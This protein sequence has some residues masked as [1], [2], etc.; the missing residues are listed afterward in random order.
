MN[1]KISIV[2]AFYNRQALLDK[3]LESIHKSSVQN[4]E[5][6]IV[7]DA[8]AE[9]LVCDEAKIIR[10]DKKDK[11]YTCSAVA[12]NRGFREATGDIVIIQNPECYHVGDILKYVRDNIKNNQYYSFACYAINKDETS[13]FQDGIMP[14]IQNKRFEDGN[15]WYN[16]SEYRPVGY[17]FCSAIM[18]RDL[19]KIGGFDERYS[20]GVAFDDDDFIRYIQTVGMDVKIIN[21]PYV[22]HQFHTHF[23]MGKPS[24]WRPYHNKNLALF[25]SGVNLDVPKDYS[26][27][28]DFYPDDEYPWGKIIVNY[29]RYYQY[30]S[31]DR[32]PIIPKILHFLW[33][34]GELPLTY[35]KL[36]DKWI[37]L[38]PTWEFKI[39][40]KKELNSAGITNSMYYKFEILYLYGGVFVDMDFKAIKP[41]D[42]L[43]YLD[44]FSGGRDINGKRF[45]PLLLDG[46][47]ASV[48][49]G[50]FVESILQDIGDSDNNYLTKKY[51]S[52]IET[53][54]DKTVLFP[55]A[56]F[57]PMPSG[58]K[59]EILDASPAN[60]AR[61]NT[62]VRP[63]TYC[64]HL[65]HDSVPKSPVTPTV[66]K[67]I[68]VEKTKEKKLELKR[69]IFNSHIQ[70][71]ISKK[72]YMRRRY[73]DRYNSR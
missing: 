38:H 55:D 11:W 33:L 59:D 53:S 43:L 65:W 67:P 52:Y 42:D 18:R 12:F 68:P 8:S 62:Y 56:F 57:Y 60:E 1:R 5:L 3:T 73:G 23:E 19:D 63:N 2:T 16:H 54:F 4:Y 61:I 50:K 35:I 36:I 41:L 14:I 37:E 39:W 10:V 21:T 72:K 15:G 24:A 7:D 30:Y 66:S 47:M 25:N 20:R 22:I 51:I 27:N 6:I 69:K 28:V 45:S 70:R 48:P 40:T 31:G 71:R 44:F 9:P 13:M 26:R 58:F 17:H 46:L 49:K 64:V 29:R 32:T 34:N